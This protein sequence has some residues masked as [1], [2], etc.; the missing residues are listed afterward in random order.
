MATEEAMADAPRATARKYAAGDTRLRG[1]MGT[2]GLLFTVL[3]YNAPVGVYVALLPVTIGMGN[4]LGAPVAF[5]AAGALLLVFAVGFCAMGRHLPNPGAFY[6]Y[7]TAGLGRPAGLAASFLALVAYN[8]MLLGNFAFFGLAMQTLVHDVLGGPA[9]SWWWAYTGVSML[10]VGI[11]GY[12]NI[13]ISA[14]VLTIGLVVELVL[15]GVYN[16]VVIGRQVSHGGLTFV[17][18]TPAAVFAGSVGLGLL[19]AITCF[20]G[21]EA[22]AIFRDEVISPERTVPRATYLAVALITVLYAGG[23]W[24]LIQALGADD[25]V[26]LATA[27]PTGSFLDSARA[28]LSRLGADAFVV[29]VLTSNFAGTLAN[30][31]IASRYLFNLSS[32]GVM[33]KSFGTVHD[34]H[35]SPHRASLATS[36]L[37]VIAGAVVVATIGV[38]PALYAQLIGMGGYI[39]IILLLATALAVLFYLNRARAPG[40]TVW[41]RVVA[42]TIAAAGLGV[43]LYLA[44]DNLALLIAGSQVVANIYVSALIAITCCAACAAIVLRRVKPN[45]YRRIGRRDV[46][47]DTPA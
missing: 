4:G 35:G 3:A 21:F 38:G 36:A 45:V 2:G 16:L 39:V 25:A 24:T 11:I 44:T 8:L 19:F 43:A 7:V 47:S 40:T 1:Q 17:S 6:A 12:R 26:A 30:H 22:T 10:L 41:H 46:S 15:I 33:L 28:Y 18:F 5:V 32:D 31:N 14:R 20:G 34:N 29:M 42:P 37:M 23:T 13:E 9:I 27:D